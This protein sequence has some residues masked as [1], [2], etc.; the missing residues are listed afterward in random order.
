MDFETVLKILVTVAGAVG[1]PVAAYAAIVATRAIWVRNPSGSTA[2]RLEAEVESLKAQLAELA[3][4]G[5]RLAELEERMDF[6]E[7][8]L[9][10][11]RPPVLHEADTPPEPLPAGR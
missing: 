11:A 5:H 6:A 7:R 1:I 4:S 2:E 3:E 9:V 8:L 10:Q